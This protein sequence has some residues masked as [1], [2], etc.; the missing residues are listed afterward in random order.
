MDF[1]DAIRTHLAGDDREQE[2]R[3]RLLEALL[4]AFARG[5]RNA[6]KE[7]VANRLDELTGALDGKLEALREKF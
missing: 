6:V 3:G 2:R 1:T 4:A 5:G 7:E